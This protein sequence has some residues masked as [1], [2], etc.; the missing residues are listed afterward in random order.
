[1]A[2]PEVTAVVPQPEAPVPL[3]AAIES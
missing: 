2:R 3:V 1:V